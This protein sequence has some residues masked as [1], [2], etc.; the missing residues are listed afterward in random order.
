MGL[1][2]IE[3]LL[4][5]P[6][7]GKQVY[8]RSGMFARYGLSLTRANAI[9]LLEGLSLGFVFVLG[10]FALME[11]LGWVQFKPASDLLRVVAEGLLSALGI[12]FAEELFFR[13]WL[14]DE[15]ER[16][17][18]PKISLWADATIFALLHFLKPIAEIIR[19]FPQ[20]PGLILLGLVLV[21]AKRSRRNHLG[22]SIGLHAGLVW[23]YYIL[24]VGQLVRSTDTV[25]PWITGVDGNPVAGMMGLLG[26]SILAVW[27]RARSRELF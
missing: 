14:L 27:L 6:L 19:T 15:L 7:W 13:G 4:F 26:L 22:I 23:G 9:A 2:G 20:F 17:Y 18:S 1:L 25:S 16:D 3:F 10:L 5:V 21:W 24:N 8:R 11:R 12:G